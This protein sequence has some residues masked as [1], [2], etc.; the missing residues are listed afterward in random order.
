MAEATLIDVEEGNRGGEPTKALYGCT[1]CAEKIPNLRARILCNRCLNYHLCS[2]CYVIKSYAKPHVDSH[3]IKVITQSGFFVPGAPA[4]PP[5]NTPA[6]PPRPNATASA[7]AKETI[8]IP[9]ADWGLLW[10][11]M[12][13]PLQK[14]GQKAPVTE[15]TKDVLPIEIKD[16]TG[17]GISGSSSNMPPSP[18]RSVDLLDYAAPMYPMPTKWEP[19]FAADS[20]PTPTFIALM[21]TIFSHLDS[22]HTGYL[23]PE[24]YSDFLDIQG[25][26]WNENVCK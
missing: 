14:K 17:V 9:T 11:I 8:E 13:A 6:L 1:S 23:S 4:V 2:N 18:P 22:L 10:S 12:K 24:T 3:Q 7:S 5:K 20:T 16:V 21:S 26:Q 15:K 25:Y 19:L